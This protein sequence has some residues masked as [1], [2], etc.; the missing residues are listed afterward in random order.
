MSSPRSRS[1]APRAAA[2][3][4]RTPLFMLRGYVERIARAELAASADLT[5][6]QE[7]ATRIDRLIDDLSAFSKLDLER[8]ELHRSEDNIGEVLKTAATEYVDRAGEKDI[9]ISFTGPG[10]LVVAAD[11]FAIGRV[12]SNL[13]DNAIRHTQPG[14][15]IEI[16]WAQRNGEISLAVRDNGEG[17]T[18]KDLPH[19]FEPLYRADTSRNSTSG[20]SGL[21]LA[22]ARRL[23][24]AHSGTLTASNR[25][26]GAEFIA[27]IPLVAEHHH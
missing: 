8:R 11:E 22:I 17:I 5:R 15:R 3:D 20:G 16:E 10:E 18:D 9:T 13:L 7:Q 4:L 26:E 6:T 23:V 24:E 2:H 19:L 12:V 27:T 25:R 21:G 14:G 1:S